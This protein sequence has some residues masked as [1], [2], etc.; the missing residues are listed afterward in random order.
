MLPT[1]LCCAMFVMCVPLYA[2]VLHS[3][4]TYLC[5]NLK[6]IISIHTLR[7]YF[8]HTLDISATHSCFQKAKKLIIIRTE[9]NQKQKTIKF[10]ILLFP[11]TML[12]K[13]ENIY[14]QTTFI[15]VFPISKQVYLLNQNTQNLLRVKCQIVKI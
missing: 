3:M 11:D 12:C 13:D 1:R 9:L 15:S 10:K 4:Q 2:N 8:H 6:R 14:I 7:R 5:Q